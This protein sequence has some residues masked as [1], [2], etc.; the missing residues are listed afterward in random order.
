MKRVKL[1]IALLMVFLL[2]CSCQKP[3]TDG[4]QD[5]IS[6]SSDS[7]NSSLSLQ[8][9]YCSN[10]TINPYNTINKIN[11]EIGDLL[12]EP[13]IKLSNDFE[14]VY[15]LA[16]EISVEGTVCNVKLRSAL[17][18]DQT[19]VTADDVIN[20]FNLAKSSNRYS[21]LFY[22]VQRAYAKDK[23]QKN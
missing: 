13:L 8:L 15:A 2:L 22:E 18:S 3:Q 5:N 19:A 23:S 10:D 17:F 16:Q 4:N 11:A 1:F 21:Y 7:Q 6:N 14:P 12:Y 20:S 9:L